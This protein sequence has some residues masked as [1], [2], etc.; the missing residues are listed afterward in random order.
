M[1]VLERPSRGGY[2]AFKDKGALVISYH[3]EVREVEMIIAATSKSSRTIASCATNPRIR[4]RE[5]GNQ[6]SMLIPLC[7]NKARRQRFDPLMR[8]QSAFEGAGILFLDND[9]GGGIGVRLA[10]PKP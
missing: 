8:I 6:T 7:A 9:T 2:F 10:T 4:G 3:F 1:G 5:F